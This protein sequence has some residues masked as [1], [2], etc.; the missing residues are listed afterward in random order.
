MAAA[1]AFATKLYMDDKWKLSKKEGASKS[2]RASSTTTSSNLL[3]RNSSSKSTR[4]LHRSSST[5]S[6]RVSFTRKCASLVKEQR[7]KSFDSSTRSVKELHIK[8]QICEGVHLLTSSVGSYCVV[9]F[10]Y[11]RDPIS[12]NKV[13]RVKNSRL[14]LE[15]CSSISAETYAYLRDFVRS[16]SRVSGFVSVSIATHSRR[17][18]RN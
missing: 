18:S 3:L 16:M 8:H 15:I 2:C 5:T 13:C 6:S 10:T 4:S 11:L 9:R 14:H 1:D 7:A 17:T 12:L